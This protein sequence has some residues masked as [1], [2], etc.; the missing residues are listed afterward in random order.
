MSNYA[1]MQDPFVEFDL[2]DQLPFDNGIP[3]YLFAIDFYL[4]GISEYGQLLFNPALGTIADYGG[5]YEL[6]LRDDHHQVLKTQCMTDKQQAVSWYTPG[7]TRVRHQCLLATAT[8][9]E[10]TELERVRYVKLLLPGRFRIIWL[11]AVEILM[12]TVFELPPSSPPPPPLPPASPSPPSPPHPPETPPPTISETCTF[13]SA[14]K[15][16][17]G[18]T[19]YEIV[20]SEPCGLT[21]DEC[22]KKLYDLNDSYHALSFQITPS[23]CCTLFSHAGNPAPATVPAP[24]ETFWWPPAGTGVRDIL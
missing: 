11:E 2:R 4:S 24:Q 16:S 6:E 13:Y 15:F 5:G 3:Y 1:N 9:D 19:D 14:K 21:K 22:C 18:T 10:V 20:L 7:I 8:P 17:A 12:R 23:G